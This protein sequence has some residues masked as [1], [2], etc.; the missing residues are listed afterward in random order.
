MRKKKQIK[1]KNY[2]PRKKK[3]KARFLFQLLFQYRKSQ[4]FRFADI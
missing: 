2:K 3:L 1:A 4:S